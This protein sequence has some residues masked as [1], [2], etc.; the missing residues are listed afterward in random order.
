MFWSV[1]HCRW[2]PCKGASEVV[3]TTWSA[4]DDSEDVAAA[5]PALPEQ[6]ADQ[7]VTEQV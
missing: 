3:A 2:V 1:E 6:R 5:P 7:P 4:S